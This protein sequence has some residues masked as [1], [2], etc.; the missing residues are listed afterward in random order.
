[1]PAR[2]RAMTAEKISQTH[3]GAESLAAGWAGVG[4][5]LS[6]GVRIDGRRARCH[7]AT[8]RRDPRGVGPSARGHYASRAR[9]SDSPVIT[10]ALAADETI[11]REALRCLLEREPDFRIVGHATSGRDALRL[12]ARRKP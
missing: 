5:A 4:L 2:K 8:V 6:V 7:P 3:R 12:V 10:I 11:I 1:M 9:V